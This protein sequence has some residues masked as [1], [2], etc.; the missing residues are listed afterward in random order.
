MRTKAVN[1]VIK[2]D[3][4]IQAE[5][6][7]AHRLTKKLAKKAGGDG[8]E[9]II[10]EIETT[11][12]NITKLKEKVSEEQERKM[13]EGAPKNSKGV[14]DHIRTFK[15]YDNDI[16]PIKSTKGNLIYKEEEKRTEFTEYSK[17]LQTTPL[18]EHIVDN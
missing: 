16:G 18:E 1:K 9:A 8:G 4:E 6:N 10:K 17:S 7:E 2:E 15:R 12:E 5:I 11:L 13:F 14:F 3:P